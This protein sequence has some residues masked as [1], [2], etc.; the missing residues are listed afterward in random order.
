MTDILQLAAGSWGGLMGLAPV[1]QIRRIIQRRSS[2]D[3]SLGYLAVLLVGFVLWL[4]Y[5]LSIG[6]PAIV[7][8]NVA[9]LSACVATIATVVVFRTRRPAG[10]YEEVT[11]A[12]G[13]TERAARRSDDL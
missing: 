6:D 7:V 1:F 10:D 4:S 5:G 12:D 3:V 11:R 9:S 8:T 13:F 2:A